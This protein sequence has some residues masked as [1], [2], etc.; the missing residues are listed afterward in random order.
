[1]KSGVRGG[2][3]EEDA[4]PLLRSQ[5]VKLSPDP[6]PLYRL[7]PMLTRAIPVPPTAPDTRPLP[8]PP[9]PPHIDTRAPP[10]TPPPLTC[11]HR[12]R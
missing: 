4:A 8:L 1:M 2:E 3:E 11:S 12:Y 10:T 6:D 5:Q 9:S 7:L